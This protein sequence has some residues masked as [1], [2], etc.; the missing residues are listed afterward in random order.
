V[1]DSDL[2][3][4]CGTSDVPLVY[5]TIG[6][7]LTATAARCAGREA[8]VVRHQGLRMTWAELDAAVTRLAAGLLELGL[9]PGDRIGIWSPNR[10]EW[11]LTQLASARA[12]LILVCINPAY[13]TSELEFALNKVGCRALVTAQRLKT[14][15]YLAMLGE[16]APE[17]ASAKPGALESVRLPD[18]RWILTLGSETHPGCLRFDDVA[19]APVKRDAP[20]WRR[21]PRPCRPTTRSTS[22]S[23]PG[24]PARPRARR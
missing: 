13:R 1:T 3:F 15:D 21:S 18:L 12:G 8:L 4:V 22:S 16:L 5:R 7:A 20:G 10:A 6:D 23:P 17:L 11:V 9:G 24:P 2:S 19:G 14:S